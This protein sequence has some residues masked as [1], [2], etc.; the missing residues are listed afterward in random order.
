MN[1]FLCKG[2]M[3]NKH[4]THTVDINNSIII[5]KNVPAMV[6]TQCGEIWYS[7]TVSRHLEKI[8]DAIA[9]TALTEIAIINYS[10]KVA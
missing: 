3:E 10:E 5:V 7:G 2:D 9:E 4:V 1:C 6:C 8:V